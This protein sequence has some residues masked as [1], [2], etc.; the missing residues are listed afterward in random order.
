[1]VTFGDRKAMKASTLARI[2]E[3]IVLHVFNEYDSLVAQL[4]EAKQ[5]VSSPWYPLWI[6]R[7]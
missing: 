3:D 7:G 6:I 1:M 4:P 5:L 2:D